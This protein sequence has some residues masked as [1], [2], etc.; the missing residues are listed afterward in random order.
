MR[1][2]TRYLAA[3]SKRGEDVKRAMSREI[4]E[5]LSITPNIGQLLFEIASP[6]RI[7]YYFLIEEALGV[8]KIGGP[9][10]ERMTEDNQYHLESVNFENFKKLNNFYPNPQNA[11]EK[12]ITVWQEKLNTGHHE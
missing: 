3:Q 12:I 1:N 10:A 4:K 6:D 8:P 7:D 2:T 9:E 11:K 5:E